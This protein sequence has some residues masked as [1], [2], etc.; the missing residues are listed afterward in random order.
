MVM[1]KGYMF[2]NIVHICP[3]ASPIRRTIAM[4]NF[5]YMIGLITQLY[6]TVY[7]VSVSYIQLARK[8]YAYSQNRD[9]NTVFIVW[10]HTRII[11]SFSMNFYAYM[12]SWG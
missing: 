1:K 5:D 4:L 2:F 6:L 3:F 10:V 9:E 12:L 7:S 8:L 11:I